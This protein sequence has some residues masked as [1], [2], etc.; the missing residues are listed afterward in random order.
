VVAVLLGLVACGQEPPRPVGGAGPTSETSSAGPADPSGPAASPTAPPSSA[1]P[2]RSAAASRKPSPKPSSTLKKT[3]A[4]GGDTAGGPA[5]PPP[6]NDGV[7]RNGAGTFTG[8]TGG[9]DVVGTG[10]TLVKYRVE[11]E[12]GIPWGSTPVVTSASF[13]VAVDNAIAGP[14]GWTRSAESPITYA[15]NHL[16]NASWSFQRVS[17]NEYSVRIRLATPDTVDKLCAAVGVQTQG[18]YS[19]RYGQ[20]ILVNLRRWLKGIAGF[21]AGIAYKDMVIN[22]ELGHF[23]GF[24]HMKCPGDGKVAPV[25]QVQTITLNGCTPNAFPFGG[26]GTFIL[27]PWAPS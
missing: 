21:P 12:D 20:T 25:M 1:Q 14:Q 5:K 13:A 24:D 15:D 22:H 16:T 27:G 8:A 7:P 9:T 6:S 19:C 3:V 23:L 10:A 11:V 18:I 17:G 26:D 4:A 2:L